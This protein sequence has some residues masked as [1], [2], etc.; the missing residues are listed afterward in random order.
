VANILIYS[1]NPQHLADWSHALISEHNVN[2]LL[3]MHGEF[4]ADAVI[5]DAEKLENDVSFLPL[6]T[7]KSAR[8]LVVGRE[9]SEQ[10]Q[11]NLLLHGASGYCEMSDSSNLLGRAIDCILKG[12]VWIKRSLVPKVIS[13]LNEHKQ[14]H[15]SRQIIAL[16]MESL[17]EMFATL[18]VRELEVA[19]MIGQG[20][21]N[22]RIAQAMNISER[23]V[24]AHLSAVFRKLAVEDRLR[25]A[26]RL[27]EIEQYR[28]LS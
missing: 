15:L 10:Q 3:N 9:W 17:L 27:K 8:F 14:S 26:I 11:I 2:T 21:S 19:N 25:L 23:T 24:K 22:K 13:L 16:D 7:N 4:H 1:H 18:S 12:D 20:E 28:N 5:F 6:F